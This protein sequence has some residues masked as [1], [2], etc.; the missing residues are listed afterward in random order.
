MIYKKENIEFVLKKI[1]QT[2]EQDNFNFSNS[3]FS[4]GNLGYCLYYYYHFLLQNNNNDLDKLSFYLE[5]SIVDIN[6]NNVMYYSPTHIIEIGRLI[7]FFVSEKLLD[8]TYLQEFFNSSKEILSTYLNR[9]IQEKNFDNT[10]GI[11]A[12]GNYLLDLFELEIYK[13]TN[14]IK[15]IFTCLQDN[16]IF[17]D[18]R[19]FWKFNFRKLNTPFIELGIFHGISGI[20]LFLLRILRCKIDIKQVK[21]YIQ[22]TCNFIISCESH[23]N[24]YL[25]PLDSELRFGFP[26]S[27]NLAYGDLG[28][29]YSLKEAGIRLDSNEIIEKANNI[30]K[31]CTNFRCNNNEINDAELIYGA[32][33]LM[34]FFD[35]IYYYNKKH[36]YKKSTHYW[37]DKILHFNSQET[38]YA[39]FE[40]YMN[41]FREDVQYSFS[42]GIIGISIALTCYI[43]QIPHKY[44]KLIN[45]E[46]YEYKI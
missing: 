35:N 34:A 15:S 18:N 20:I 41:G 5:K 37:I 19:C 26:N 30:I 21:Y 1:S 28:I 29:G 43:L 17:N 9:K 32:S 11:L 3:G 24:K 13:D 25:F 4:E 23:S 27:I 6:E 46:S 33:G 16:A 39:G 42:H 45:Y 2:I 22:S 38:K 12:V 36:I 7:A 40:T 10:N 14:T 44:L 31:K 8:S